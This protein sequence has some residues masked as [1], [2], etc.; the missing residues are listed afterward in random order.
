MPQAR[1]E[2]DVLLEYDTFGDPSNPTLLLI[3]GFTAQLTLWEEGFCQR[4]A[5]GG[6]HVVR[7]DNRDCGLSTKFDGRD[8]DVM[9]VM[10]A[11]LARVEVPSVPY[12]L[13]D[14]AADAV[15]LLDV[16]GVERAH[17]VGASMGGMIAQTVVLEHPRRVRSLTAIMTSSGNP[18]VGG[19]TPEAAA[20]LFTPARSDRD[21]YIDDSERW[22]VFQ[23]KRYGNAADNRAVAA[24][25][26]DRSY[27][28]QGA[29]RQLA[30]IFASGVRDELLTAV[31][32]PTLVIHGR[33]D[34]LITPPAG[35]HLASLIPGA[36]LM[37][38]DDMGH[39]M[40]EPLWP[41]LT[42]AIIEHVRRAG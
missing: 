9:A 22:L 15:A 25:N 19:P 30:A 17:L 40:P 6:F 32:T 23:S 13:S 12:T 42:A 5:D 3:T 21:G 33:D 28:P 24:R 37:M 1:L 38:V 36:R 20:V 10:A 4:L 14:M 31:D 18:D 35:E 8:V 41:I 39:D 29:P 16:L 7:F 11:A 34:T 26:Y 27:Y 2:H